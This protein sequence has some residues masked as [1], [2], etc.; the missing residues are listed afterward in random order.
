MNRFD[1]QSILLNSP[2]NV[3]HF[4]IQLLTL[5]LLAPVQN[6]APL[7]YFASTELSCNHLHDLGNVLQEL[8]NSALRLVTCTPE[9]RA[10][11][12]ALGFCAR[13]VTA[14]ILSEDRHAARTI[15]ITNFSSVKYDD[16]S[17]S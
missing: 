3:P 4:F 14:S 11:L 5:A 10:K 8:K 12:S 7:D 1:I 9:A 6:T 15:S 13:T 17:I 16:D 2:R